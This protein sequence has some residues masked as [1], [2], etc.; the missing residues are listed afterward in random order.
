MNRRSNDC[1][2]WPFTELDSFTPIH[3]SSSRAKPISDHYFQQGEQRPLESIHPFTSLQ[4]KIAG[5]LFVARDPEFRCFKLEPL[6]EKVR[7]IYTW[8]QCRIHTSDELNNQLLFTAINYE[9]GNNGI[10]CP[11]HSILCLFLK[12]TSHQAVG[13]DRVITCVPWELA[14]RDLSIGANYSY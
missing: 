5:L 10:K 2:G 12:V 14:L 7:L 4:P 13:D 11:S 6:G 3:C 9:C 8:K 1:I